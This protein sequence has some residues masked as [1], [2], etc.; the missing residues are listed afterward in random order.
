MRAILLALFGLALGLQPARAVDYSRIDRKVGKEPAY[1]SKAP[2]YALL[3]FGPQ[4]ALRVWVVLDGEEVYLDRNGDGDLTG[5]DEHFARLE[6][7]KDVTLA[8]TDGK[9]KYVVTGVSSFPDDRDKAQRHLMV[10]VDIRGPLAYRQYCDVRTAASPGKSALAHFHG[11]LTAGPRTINWKLPPGLTL[12][13]GDKPTDLPAVVGTMSAEH[14]CWVVVRSQKGND[15][16]FAK[17]VRPVLD[18]EFPPKAEGGKAV[19]KRYVL[20]GFC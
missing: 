16:A 3:L 11:P 5:K 8:D 1:R 14:G 13:T 4:A 19:K 15:C 17:G 7:C 18:V 9:T 20:D 12:A 2:K 6:Q 10:N